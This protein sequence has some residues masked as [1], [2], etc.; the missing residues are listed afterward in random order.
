MEA[1]IRAQ[2][3]DDGRCTH[4]FD[5]LV[6]WLGPVPRMLNDV[7]LEQHPLIFSASALQSL[8]F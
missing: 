5:V 6:A 2:I 8:P 4:W 1:R 3:R 7:V